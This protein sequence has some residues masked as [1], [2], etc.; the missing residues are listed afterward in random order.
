VLIFGCEGE[1]V[2]LRI[3]VRTLPSA[4]SFFEAVIALDAFL[5]FGTDDHY[6]PNRAQFIKPGGYVG[7]EHIAFTLEIESAEDAPELL[8][9]Q[10]RH[11]FPVPTVGWWKRHWATTDLADLKWTDVLLESNELLRMW[12]DDKP[13]VQNA[14][15]IMRAVPLDRHGLTALFCLVARK[16]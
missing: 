2:P 16:R 11:W 10:F 8:R 12:A 15:S 14:G 3:D 13:T 1:V 7:L 5:Y 4:A 6:L 9:A